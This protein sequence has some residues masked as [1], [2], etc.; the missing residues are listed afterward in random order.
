M[1][2]SLS[3]FV[4]ANFLYNF[5]VSLIYIAMLKLYKSDYKK[6]NTFVGRYLVYVFLT[7]FFHCTRNEPNNPKCKRRLPNLEVFDKLLENI[8]MK[9]NFKT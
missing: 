9:L 5:L 6:K 7:F 3:F 2:P 8:S 1:I 4:K